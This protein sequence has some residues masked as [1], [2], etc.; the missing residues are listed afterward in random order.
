MAGRQGLSQW[1][2]YSTYAGRESFG[3]EQRRCDLTLLVLI[4]ERLQPE[5]FHKLTEALE[6]E[7]RRRGTPLSKVHYY[8]PVRSPA[9]DGSN[10][11]EGLEE[12]ARGSNTSEDEEEEDETGYNTTSYPAS[13]TSSRIFR[14][15][16]PVVTRDVPGNYISEDEDAGLP[17]TMDLRSFSL[18]KAQK[19]VH[20]HTKNGS[21]HF[22]RSR[23][24]GR[25]GSSEMRPTPDLP[26]E[27]EKD[28]E[29]EGEGMDQSHVNG[30]VLSALLNLYQRPPSMRSGSFSGQSSEY[31]GESDYSGDAGSSFRLLPASRTVSPRMAEKREEK[32][33]ELTWTLLWI[34]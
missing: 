19:V 24:H 12:V 33:S 26:S 15:T 11:G 16:P 18:R 21:D 5:A 6:L 30:G 34:N 20:T 7:R 31:G 32:K 9:S 28:V 22:Q 25:S 1:R 29:N 14:G 10:D 4:D 8:P 17:G 13:H 2:L 27:S 23:H 3:C